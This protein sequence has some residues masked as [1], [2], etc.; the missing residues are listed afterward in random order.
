MVDLR[1]QKMVTSPVDDDVAPTWL[2]LTRLSDDQ[3]F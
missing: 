1:K 2:S 3:I